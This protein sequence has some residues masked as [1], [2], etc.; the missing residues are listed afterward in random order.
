M[1]LGAAT[2]LTED[3]MPRTAEIDAEIAR[4][5]A[6]DISPKGAALVAMLVKGLLDRG[7][8]FL[9]STPARELVMRDGAVI[10]VRVTNEGDEIAIGARRGVVLAC[11]GFEWNH[12]MVMTLIGYDVKPLSPGGNTGDGLLMAVEAGARL[13]NT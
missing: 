4:R 2:T 1:S 9:L 12:A 3:F 13:A 8:E 5:E 7:V 10:G 6:E 11:G